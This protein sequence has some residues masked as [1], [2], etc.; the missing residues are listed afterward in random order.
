VKHGVPWIYGA[1]IGAEGRVMAVVPGVT[2]CLRCVF[3]T[4]PSPQDLPT[5]D[6]AGVL[7]MA[8]VIVGAYQ[9]TEAIKLL[10]GQPPA[11][12]LIRLDVWS[13]R[14][15]VVSTADAKR[16]DCPTC[17]LHRFDYLESR[18]SA[19]AAALCGRNA[20]Q[21]RPPQ[22]SDVNLTALA[23]RLAPLGHVRRTP[24]FVKIAL[25]DPAGVTLTVFPDGR[26]LIHGVTDLG[27]AKSLHARFV[28]S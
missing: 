19:A 12:Y 21:V 8:T 7:G 26:S 4:P 11:P 18:S 17:G 14:T 3:P 25:R 15:H 1:A 6:T 2:P 5:C 13:P 24:H 27:R 22:S 23:A 28:G 20:V 9:A 10:T 16:T